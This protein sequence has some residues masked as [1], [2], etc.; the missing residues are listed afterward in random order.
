MAFPN[1]K[2]K[3][4]KEAVFSPKDFLEYS[5]SRNENHRF[6]LPKNFIF[7]FSK[8]FLNHLILHHRAY[9][10]GDSEP[11]IYLFK[12]NKNLGIVTDFGIG[13]PA[14]VT[15]MEE[16][17]AAGVKNF[18]IAGTA[19]TIQK[20]IKIGDIVVCDRAIRDE[21]TSHHYV[22]LSKYAYASKGLVNKIKN[23]LDK[24]E[25]KY[26]IGTS[27]T[28]DAPYRETVAEVKKY[29]REGVA[30]TEMEASAVFSVAKYRKVKAAAMFTVSD[31]LAELKWN[32]KFHLSDNNWE[33]LFRAAKNA[34]LK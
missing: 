4:S 15:V 27:L 9:K 2:N 7:C 14:T 22:K 5:K 8:G 29:Q 33:I 12:N 3:H 11:Q 32:P 34:L 25:R 18:V 13:S 28:T 10:A 26:F 21:G 16:L 17:I 31:S 24:M 1:F 6:K 20:D 30:T 19:G 23:S